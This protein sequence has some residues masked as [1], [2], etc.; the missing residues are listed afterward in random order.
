MTEKMTEIKALEA[1]IAGEITPEV[2]EKLEA[3]VATR[4]KPRNRKKDDSK[5]LANIALGEEFVNAWMAKDG[6]NFKASDVAAT[7]GVTPAKASAICKAMEW[8][9]VP[10][11]EKVNV[12]SL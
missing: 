6:G 10:S 3:M 1:A 9:R 8:N 12:Y 11:T 7:L 2:R 4:K 5:R